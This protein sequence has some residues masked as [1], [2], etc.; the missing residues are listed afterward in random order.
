M[1]IW[2]EHL[3]NNKEPIKLT[4]ISIETLNKLNEI[5]K[6]SDEW[7]KQAEYRQSNNWWIKYWQKIYLK[8]LILKRT[9]K[10]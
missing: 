8:Y 7:I 2:E 9:M 3:E 10:L 6:P 4:P 5:S 1:Y